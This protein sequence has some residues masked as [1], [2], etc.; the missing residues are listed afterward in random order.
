MVRETKKTTPS[1]GISTLRQIPKSPHVLRNP[2]FCVGCFVYAKF[3]YSTQD[4]GELFYFCDFFFADVIIAKDMRLKINILFAFLFLCGKQH[5]VPGINYF[6]KQ[7]GFAQYGPSGA[8]GTGGLSLRPTPASFGGPRRPP[9]PRSSNFVTAGQLRGRRMCAS[10]QRWVWGAICTYVWMA[11]YGML[12]RLGHDLALFQYTPL[13]PNTKQSPA[14]PDRP[15][16]ASQRMVSSSGSLMGAKGRRGR[17]AKRGWGRAVEVG[18]GGGGDVGQS[19][20][21]EPVFTMSYYC[22]GLQLVRIACRLD[23]T[24]CEPH[25][26]PPYYCSAVVLPNHIVANQRQRPPAGTQVGKPEAVAKVLRY[27][28]GNCK[29]VR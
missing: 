10:R 7:L 5:P 28:V 27:T 15:R 21:G 18:Q 25:Q 2:N 6:R 17:E 11:V 22:S 29:K 20:S 8:P 14:S 16:S 1:V 24:A 9:P 19:E 26:V 13:E 23:R 4:R 3:C 12:P